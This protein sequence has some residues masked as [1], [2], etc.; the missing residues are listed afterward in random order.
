MGPMNR[1]HPSPMHHQTGYCSLVHL[2]LVSDTG[3]CFSFEHR[4]SCYYHQLGRCQNNCQGYLNVVE[5]VHGYR[6]FQIQVTFSTGLDLA[7]VQ[8]AESLRC[9]MMK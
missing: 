4:S 5:K 6:I 2:K 7:K 3:S 9:L 1:G 8:L